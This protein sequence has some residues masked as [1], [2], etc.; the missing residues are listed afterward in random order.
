M[1]QP[2]VM[3]AQQDPVFEVCLSAE[4]PGLEVVGVAPFWWH[5]AAFGLAALLLEPECF[6]LDG[7]EESAVAAGVE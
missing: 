4:C 7:L 6:A 2:V 5:V 3:G 1:G